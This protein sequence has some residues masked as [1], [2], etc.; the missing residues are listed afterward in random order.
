M[1]LSNLNEKDQVTSIQIITLNSIFN[2]EHKKI[3]PEIQA[4]ENNHN[5]EDKNK[6]CFFDKSKLLNEIYKD[7]DDFFESKCREKPR[8][9]YEEVMKFDPIFKIN[10]DEDKNISIK[11]CRVCF[12]I[13][14]INSKLI[15]PCLC[16]G[17]MKY[18]HDLCLKKW[19]Y[20]NNYIFQKLKNKM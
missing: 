15:S 11:K 17:S 5:N 9:L 1:D 4:F 14:S 16:G 18:I 2:S 20:S 12:E 7:A 3:N 8:V 6:P 13:E 19:I 10:S